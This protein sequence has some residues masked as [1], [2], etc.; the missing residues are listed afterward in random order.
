MI[1]YIKYYS[2]IIALMLFSSCEKKEFT[3]GALTAPTE[4]V[5]NTTIVGVDATHPNGD[6]SGDVKIEIVGK[7]VSVVQDRLQCR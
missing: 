3:M 7:N 4:V 6:G 1:R 2:F 5:I